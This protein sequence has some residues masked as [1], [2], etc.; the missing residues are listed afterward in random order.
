M[1]RICLLMLTGWSAWAAIS[2]VVTNRTTGKPQA[3]VEIGVM[4]MSQ[5]GMEPLGTAKSGTG[6]TFTIEKSSQG[7]ALL[8]A[9]WQGVSY[10]QVLTPGTPTTG[11]A[12]NVYDASK[13]PG[14]AKVNQHLVLFEPA[15]DKLSVS[16]TYFFKNDGDK[17]YHDPAN[18]TLRFFL[19]PAAKG[20]VQVRATAP[21]GVPLDRSAEKTGKPGT[22][23]VDFPIKP[24]E[25]RI[26]LAFSVPFAPGGEFASRMLNTDGPT[27]LISPQ[28]VTLEGEGVSSLG[29]EP[30]TKAGIYQVTGTQYS[31]KVQGT[32]S[33]R[34]AAEGA[35]AAPEEEGG[36]G[37][38]Q[39]LPPIFDHR[40]LLVG[41][42]LGILAVGFVLLYLRGSG[43]EAESAAAK[44]KEKRRR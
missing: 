6:G 32:G 15:A 27:R 26:D 41:L 33:L 13:T 22:Y 30:Q 38:E 3:G 4:A 12:V 17:T 21:A 10:S 1:K 20:E 39:I 28:G 19:P 11:L 8:Q 31:V 36:P 7:P 5:A 42:A 44:P 25:T 23:K 35:G 2:G 14:G 37:I 34:G 18:G 9:T 16:E 40:F 43:L 24:G 29:Q